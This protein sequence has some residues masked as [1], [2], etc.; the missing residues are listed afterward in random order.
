RRITNVCSADAG[1]IMTD[2]LSACSSER[3]SFWRPDEGERQGSGMREAG[4]RR[5]PLAHGRAGDYALRCSNG[6]P[7]GSGP[8]AERRSAN[9]KNL[10]RLVPAEGLDGSFQRPNSRSWTEGDADAQ[11]HTPHQ[12]KLRSE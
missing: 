10:I 11:Y 3:E 12:R 1:V 8:A 2:A 7:P 9:P 6:V 4:H 5:E